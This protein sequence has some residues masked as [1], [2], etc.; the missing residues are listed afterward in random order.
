MAGRGRGKAAFPEVR[1]QLRRPK[2]DPED[3][4]EPKGD[5]KRDENKQQP[6]S[7]P[8]DAAPVKV[9]KE[10]RGLCSQFKYLQ[11]SDSNFDKALS[12][13]NEKLKTSKDI[14]DVVNS[15]YEICLL[16]P[17]QALGTCQAMTRLSN[18]EID[19]CK[20]RT[21][22]LTRLQQ[23]FE[24][25]EEKAE[26]SPQAF[27]SNTVF[28]CEYYTQYLL[29]G[30]PVNSL[31]APVWRYLEFML[32]SRKPYFLNQCFR[33][34]QSKVGFFMKHSRPELEGNFLT[35]L[36][37]VV[38]D[39]KVPKTHRSFGLETLELILKELTRNAS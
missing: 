4:A 39:E 10:I 32:Q 26:S 12:A 30:A 23:E 17:D 28:L 1:H 3:T 6:P 11:A 36:R 14:D 29:H 37:E 15:M 31:K 33:L 7:T 19:G 5:S 27:L 18:V 34:V 20:L 16:G 22:L 38:L 35:K 25:F 24:G 2:E 8:V 13:V 9:E 21:K